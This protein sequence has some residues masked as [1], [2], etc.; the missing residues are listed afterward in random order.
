MRLRFL[1][2]ALLA[3]APLLA[4]TPNPNPFPATVT[5]RMGFGFDASTLGLGVQ[6]AFRI[7]D[8][9]NIRIGFNDFNF[10]RSLTRDGINYGGQLNLRS[11]HA[12]YDW[13]FWGPLH[14]SPGFMLYNHN[15][16]TATA[17]APAGQTFTFSGTTYTSSST[18]PVSGSGLL[19][20]SKAGPMLTIG[21][22]NL[23]PHNPSH[24][25]VSVEAGVVYQGE[26]SVTLNFAGDVCDASGANCAPVSTFPGFTTSVQ[27]EEAQLDHDLRV[28]KLYPVI[29][30]VFGF[31]M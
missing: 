18:T 14:L 17:L 12:S 15:R 16:G 8:S 7:T 19:N 30:L 23:V 25:I 29:S 26:P 3:S 1:A 13:Y 31:S 2:L 20:L 22:G 24:F 5:P 27:Q 11:L 21:V 28:F 10:A 6:G 4:Q 9:S